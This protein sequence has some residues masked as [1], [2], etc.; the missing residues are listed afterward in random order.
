MEALGSLQAP[1]ATNWLWPVG[2]AFPV[3]Q[4]NLGLPSALHFGKEGLPIK[5]VPL[6]HPKHITANT[7]LPVY[8]FQHISPFYK[9]S[10]FC[11]RV[12]SQ[13][14][15]VLQCLNSAALECRMALEKLD[16]KRN[17]KER[18][19]NSDI[20]VCRGLGF[21]VGVFFMLEINNNEIVLITQWK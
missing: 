14:T 3:S 15:Q 12:F 10:G 21:V 1:A 5:I 11:E 16:G 20:R 4:Q 17:K 9:C 13:E 8:L 18:K 2:K 19:R 6:L 7:L